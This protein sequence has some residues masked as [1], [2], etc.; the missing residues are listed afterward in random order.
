MEKS[1]FKKATLAEALRYIKSPLAK[2]VHIDSFPKT[3]RFGEKSGHLAFCTLRVD[4]Y[5][6]MPTGYIIS[7]STFDKLKAEG[8]KSTAHK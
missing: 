1:K 3:R 8:V 5:K 2:V 4:W 6:A 7:K